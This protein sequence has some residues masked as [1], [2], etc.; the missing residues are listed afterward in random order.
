[1]WSFQGGD[2]FRFFTLTPTDVTA[3]DSEAMASRKVARQRQ[4]P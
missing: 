1:V 4:E 2:L 3:Q